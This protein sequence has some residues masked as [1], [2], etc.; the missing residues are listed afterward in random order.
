MSKKAYVP[1][2]AVQDYIDNFTAAGLENL[3]YDGI[4]PN[5]DWVS[6]LV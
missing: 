1:S 2:N 4:E 3:D 5:E 6:D